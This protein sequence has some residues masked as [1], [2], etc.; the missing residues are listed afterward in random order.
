MIDYFK[1]AVLNMD[2]SWRDPKTYA[3]LIPIISPAIHAIQL[4]A[5]RPKLILNTPGIFGYGLL[6][7][8]MDD[9]DYINTLDFSND[10]KLG[11]SQKY[12]FIASL[13]RVIAYLILSFSPTTAGI[14]CFG[15]ISSL[16][17]LFLLC[18]KSKGILSPVRSEGSATEVCF[19][20][21]W[22][23]ASSFSLKD[24]LI[25]Q[26]HRNPFPTDAYI[27]LNGQMV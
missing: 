17:D 23:T 26:S 24:F 6:R 9:S 3:I 7:P 8:L 20:K 27:R 14:A 16:P 21:F 11:K 15:V 19:N 18:I 5:L 1:E 22:G 4:A 2:Y 13:I 12:F 25:A 10:E